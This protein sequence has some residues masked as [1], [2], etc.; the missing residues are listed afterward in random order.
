M[1]PPYNQDQALSVLNDFVVGRHQVLATIML[2]SMT[3]ITRY[4]MKRKIKTKNK[5]LADYTEVKT[6]GELLQEDSDRRQREAV[7][8]SEHVDPC[9]YYR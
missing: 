9:H 3:L 4:G 1:S 8:H 6:K 5:K 2:T 7:M